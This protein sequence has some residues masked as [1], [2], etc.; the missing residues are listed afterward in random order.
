MKILFVTKELPFPV[1]NGHRMRS[2]NILKGIATGNQIDIICLEQHVKMTEAKQALKAFYTHLTVIE[3]SSNSV[4]VKAITLFK[5]LF[6]NLPYSIVLR[7]SKSMRSKIEQLCS[8]TDYDCIV[9]DGIHMMINI[10]YVRTKVILSEHN[11]ESVIIQRYANIAQ[12]LR[13]WFAGFEYAKMRRF[14]RQTWAR[15]HAAFVCSQED[16]RLVCDVMNPQQVF[17]VPNG[18]DTEKYTIDSHTPKNNNSLLYTGLMGWAPNEDAVCYFADEVYSIVKSKIPDVTFTI[19]GKGPT[20]RVKALAERDSSIHVTGFVEDIQKYMRETDIFI[21][22]IRIGSGTRLK[23]LEALALQMTI[24]STSIG[25]EG[26]AVEDDQNILIRDTPEEFANAIINILQ[27]KEKYQHLGQNGR[28][29]VEG[30]YSWEKIRCDLNQYLAEL[31]Q[32]PA[33]STLNCT[34]TIAQ[35]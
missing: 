2:V 13:K 18:V 25:C 9:C 31:N 32:P 23:I 14:E 24:V 4:V 10:P 8:Q 19:V 17:T 35:T 21:V 26:L 20:E 34:T 6:T 16:Q 3:A 29:L 33:N 11:I 15:S 1:N 27:N 5:S 7:F 12:G 30:M 22:P 28:K